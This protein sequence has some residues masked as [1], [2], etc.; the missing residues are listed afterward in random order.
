[1]LGVGLR[2]AVLGSLNPKLLKLISERY[3]KETPWLGIRLVLG[4]GLL[5]LVALLV[6]AFAWA[7]LRVGFD[8]LIFGE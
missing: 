2:L 6:L 8:Q 7:K 3:H 1:M 4:G 5:V